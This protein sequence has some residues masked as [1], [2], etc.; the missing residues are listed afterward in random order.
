MEKDCYYKC[1]DCNSQLRMEK[2]I[3]KER[4][5]TID[6]HKMGSSASHNKWKKNAS[7]I[8]KKIM[9]DEKFDGEMANMKAHIYMSMKLL[10]ESDEN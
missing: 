1:F 7:V 5:M 9:S 3:E 4:K 2:L 10:Q 8:D 6:G